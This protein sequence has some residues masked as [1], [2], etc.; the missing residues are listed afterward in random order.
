MISGSKL[1]DPAHRA[2]GPCETD[3]PR[4]G[5]V[6]GAPLVDRPGPTYRWLGVV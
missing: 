3:R 5:S 4:R 6:D 2:S 1:A